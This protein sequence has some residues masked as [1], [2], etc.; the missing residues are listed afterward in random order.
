MTAALAALW[1]LLRT[2][3]GAII[4]ATLAGLAALAWWTADQRAAAVTAERAKAEL[5]QKRTLDEARSGIDD[6][7]ACERAGGVWSLRHGRCDRSV[8]RDGP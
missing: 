7:R 6:V 3:Y 1:A 2:P 8:R 5:R 4:A